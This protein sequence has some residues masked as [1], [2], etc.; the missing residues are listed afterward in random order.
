MLELFSPLF[1]LRNH[2]FETSQLGIYAQHSM[3]FILISSL[4]EALAQSSIRFFSR[5]TGLALLWTQCQTTIRIFT[6]YLLCTLVIF[7]V[8]T[9]LFQ[10]E[11]D[12]AELLSLLGLAVL[13]RVYAVYGLIPYIGKSLFRILNAWTLF[14]LAVLLRREV[15]MGVGQILTCLCVSVLAYGAIYVAFSL[16]PQVPSRTVEIVET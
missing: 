16:L 3:W 8:L 2:P 1:V 15:G 6:S 5:H 7:G 13:P 12:P 10:V 9:F 14:L 4:L 11:T